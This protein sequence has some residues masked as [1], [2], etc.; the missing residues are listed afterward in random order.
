MNYE[1]TVSDFGKCNGHATNAYN[2]PFISHCVRSAFLERC[3]DSRFP[4]ACGDRTCRRSYPECLQALQRREKLAKAR[5]GPLAG[6]PAP[7]A[8]SDAE[9]Q[10]A[11]EVGGFVPAN[12]EPD[13][14]PIPRQKAPTFH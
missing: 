6:E 9:G 4:V 12:E 13:K 5:P 14:D 11:Y 8:G 1:R 2:F 3:T 10:W 7:F